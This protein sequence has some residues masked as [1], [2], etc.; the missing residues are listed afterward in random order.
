MST[1]GQGDHSFEEALSARRILQLRGPLDDAA[2]GTLC[3][4]LM[5]LDGSG[6]EAVTMY[7]DSS[8]G[9]IQAALTVIDAIDL[10]GVPVNTV[11]L[12][13][14]QGPAVAVVAAGS[15]RRAAAHAR[16]RLCEPAAAADGQ[17]AQ[18]Q[19]WADHYLEQ[20]ELLASVL[21]RKTGQAKEHVEADIAAGR[22]LDASAAVAYG[23]VDAIWSPQARR[24]GGPGD[25]PFGF[26]R[27]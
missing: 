21:A 6:D 19:A 3:A 17:A 26:G 8:G 20:S 16:F 23:I 22:W 7:L 12:G 9:P 14:A 27:S 4:R 2:A 15:S 11:C 13:H 24:D 5:Y 18:L 1:H 10:L 25:R